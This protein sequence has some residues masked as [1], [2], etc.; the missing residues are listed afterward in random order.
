[1]QE[2]ELP[3]AGKLLTYTIVR[4]GPAEFSGQEP[5]AVGLVELGEGVRVLAQ[6]TDVALDDIRLGMDLEAVLRRYREDSNDGIIL[7]GIKFRP[8]L[9]GNTT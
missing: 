4:K 6:L 7:Y 8:K 1:M 3:S 9:S 2:V 5:Y